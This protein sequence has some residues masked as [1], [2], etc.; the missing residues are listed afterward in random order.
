MRVRVPT[1]RVSWGEHPVFLDVPQVR[2]RAEREGVESRVESRGAAL[3]KR[4]LTDVAPAG[5][6][7]RDV[8]CSVGSAV[9]IASGNCYCGS[10]R[11]R[12][13]SAP[14]RSGAERSVVTTLALPCAHASEH[15]AFDRISPASVRLA[16][17]N[18]A[19][20]A[21]SLLACGAR[22]PR[23]RKAAHFMRKNPAALR[24]ARPPASRF[25]A[26]RPAARARS[27]APWRHPRAAQ[28]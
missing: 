15:S 11:Q 24:W 6:F 2:G 5:V 12:V 18:T 21:E 9:R 20:S 26:A 1:W 16:S 7:R 19:R 3:V 28:P 17:S 22:S 13:R 8:S 25:R 10:S 14:R 23:S 27:R 4:Y